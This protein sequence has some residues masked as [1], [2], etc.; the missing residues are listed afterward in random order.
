[1]EGSHCPPGGVNGANSWGTQ[2]SRTGSGEKAKGRGESF[3]FVLGD[4]TMGDYFDVAL[5]RD[6]VYGTP[7]FKTLAGRSSCPHE[8]GTDARDQFNV[9]FARNG[10]GKLDSV[11][12]DDKTR[13]AL[14]QGDNQ[15]ISV[16][17]VVE[18][19]SPF[20]DTWEWLAEIET[21]ESMAGIITSVNAVSGN[22]VNKVLLP[23]Q[24]SSTSRKYRA[25]FCR[26]DNRDAETFHDVRIKI[27]SPCESD[28][29][30]NDGLSKLFLRE[31]TDTRQC[32]C[33]AENQNAEAVDGG[34]GMDACPSSVNA[35]SD[36]AFYSNNGEYTSS[37]VEESALSSYITISCMAFSENGCDESSETS[38]GRR[39]TTN[40]YGTGYSAA[41]PHSYT[42]RGAHQSRLRGSRAKKRMPAT[43][44]DGGYVDFDHD[45]DDEDDDDDVDDDEPEIN[46]LEIYKSKPLFGFTTNHLI[47]ERSIRGRE[48]E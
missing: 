5:A 12:N 37:L 42:S 46:T 1:M 29:S 22:M 4:E 48:K 16:Y 25:N 14:V 9:R 34:Q 23:P 45:D 33:D 7:V 43:V 38:G 41:S 13:T 6:P 27:S 26:T 18:N 20:G 2:K 19:T 44:Q 15:C 32:S 30:L 36:F 35:C 17:F 31:P 10:E 21:D 8:S 40:H 3:S 24:R 47:D 11:G 39:M 28:F